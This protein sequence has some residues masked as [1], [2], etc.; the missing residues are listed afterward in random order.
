MTEDAPGHPS[1]SA[2]LTRLLR[3]SVDGDAVARDRVLTLVYEELHRQARL[4]RHRHR[5]FETLNTTAL[6][7]ETFL[8]LWGAEDPGW[9]DRA[10]FFR[11]AARAMR[12]V[13]VDYAR[14][15]RAAKRG[16]GVVD[17]PLEAADELP[18]VKDDEILAVHDSLARLEALDPRQAKVA[19]LRYF[20]GLSV[21]E[22]AEVLEV[23]P[24]TV[25]REW[26]TAR[27][28]LQ[29]DIERAR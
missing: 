25:K 1:D 12:N 22:T 8:R 4:Q 18:E 6:V 23:S 13:L 3:A 26:A 17:L 21:V 28:W 14:R 2:D 5:A 15:R 19:E 11:V 10:H 9:Q 7:N 16:G 27:V 24:A 29:R 20:V